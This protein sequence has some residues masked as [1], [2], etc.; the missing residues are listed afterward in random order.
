MEKANQILPVG[1]PGPN[2]YFLRELEMIDPRYY[3]YYNRFEGH[4]EIICPIKDRFGEREEIKGHYAELN[5]DVLIDLRRRK[6]IGLILMGD[7]V[8]YRKW[9]KI[10]Q[11]RNKK[12]QLELSV[13]YLTEGYMKIYNWDTDKRP[14]YYA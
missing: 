5:H 6:K 7:M 12:K 8:K 13:D 4:W 10:E 2:T 9:M 3:P 14:H 11:E 1:L